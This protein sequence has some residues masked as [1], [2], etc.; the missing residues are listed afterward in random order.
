MS[1]PDPS[2]RSVAPSTPPS[3]PSGSEA[4]SHPRA[5]ALAVIVTVLWSSS[6]VLIRFGLDDA[7]L[8][9]VTFAGLRYGTAAIVLWLAL[10]ARV[11]R[12]GPIARPGRRDLAAYAALGL[13]F[14]GLT[15]GAQFVAIDRQPAATTSLLLSLTP[16]AVAGVGAVALGEGVTRRQL[17]GAATVVAGALLY[18]AGDL[19]ATAVGLL[20]A[21]VALAA[22]TTSSVAGRSVNRR[23]TSSPLVVT[24]VSMTVGAASLIAVGLAVEGVPSIGGAAIAIIAWLAVVNTALAF[25]LWNISLRSLT[26]VESSGINN[27]MLVQIALL[28]WIFLDEAPGG[29]GLLGIAVVSVGVFLT[30][31]RRH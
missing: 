24:T 18:L 12:G 8:P 22:N 17:V 3:S 14:Y 21:A 23:H 20:A 13:V 16:L 27:L 15:Q 2:S 6:W 7:D 28:A 31:T 1:R 25:T 9:P 29:F 4:V 10:A 5:I 19:G 30:Q 26:A 11:R